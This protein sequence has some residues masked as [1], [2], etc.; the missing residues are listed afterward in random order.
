MNCLQHQPYSYR[1]VK[2]QFPVADLVAQLL[3]PEKEFTAEG[4]EN[5]EQEYKEGL[6][7][8]CHPE[9]RRAIR[10]TESRDLLFLHSHLTRFS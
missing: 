8:H 9:R 5:A 3:R 10:S 7:I 4:A 2:R 1:Q 6:T